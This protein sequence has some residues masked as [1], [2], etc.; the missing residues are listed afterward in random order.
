MAVLVDGNPTD[1][2]S[3]QGEGSAAQS[4]NEFEGWLLQKVREGNLTTVIDAFENSDN[5]L[6]TE[7]PNQI[8]SIDGEGKTPVDLAASLGR[9][10]IL[11]EL[12]KHGAPIN[13]ATSTGWFN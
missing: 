6:H 10:E 5:P 9:L 13:K 4:A 1:K 2:L 7:V 8:E 12:H 11:Q 3:S